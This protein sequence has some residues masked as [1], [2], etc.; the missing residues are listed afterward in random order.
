MRRGEQYRLRWQDVELKREVIT[1]P[2]SKH[3]EER[4]IQINSTARATLLIL[5]GG[6]DR[7]GYVVPSYDGPRT[8]DWRDWFEDAVKKAGIGNFHWHDLRHTFASRLV[9]AGVPLRTVQVLMGHKSIETTLRY[10]HLAEPHLREAVERLTMKQT[11]PRTSTGDEHAWK[12][13]GSF[14]VNTLE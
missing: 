11:D 5:R 8:R 1:I 3:G 9:M 2:R 6:V 13:S 12:A 7:I 14:S 4:H 10:A